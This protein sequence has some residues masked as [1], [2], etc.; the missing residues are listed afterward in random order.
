MARQRK[1]TAAPRRGDANRPT[2]SQVLHVNGERTTQTAP[3]KHTTKPA[4]RREGKI[5][6]TIRFR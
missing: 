4:P 5:S 2:R 1:V 6:R 3:I